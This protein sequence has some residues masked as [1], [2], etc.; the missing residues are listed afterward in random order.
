M[1][2]HLVEHIHVQQLKLL[3]KSFAVIYFPTW[4]Q[5]TRTEIMR[6]LFSKISCSIDLVEL[7]QVTVDTMDDVLNYLINDVKVNNLPLFQL[8]FDGD[9][10]FSFEVAEVPEELSNPALYYSPRKIPTIYEQP[11]RAGINTIQ[12]LL[13]DPLITYSKPLKLFISGDRSSVGKSSTCLAL[14]A[15]LVEEGVLPSDLAYIKPVTQCE[16]E[17]AITRYCHEMQIEHQGI[18]PVVF[19]QGFTRA[20]LAGETESAATLI[21]KAVHAV[22]SIGQR[23]KMVIVD[24]VGYPAVGSICNIRATIP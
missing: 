16:S 10:K 12:L 7:L 24:G 20:Y 15:T 18:G 8:Y 22:E 5:R 9:L 11:Y 14:I 6:N 2:V 19:F 23:K 4:L 1:K 17:Q 3:K 13:Q 21:N